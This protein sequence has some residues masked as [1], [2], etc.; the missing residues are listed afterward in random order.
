[1]SEPTSLPTSQRSPSARRPRVSTMSRS[2]RPSAPPSSCRSDGLMYS[3][4]TDRAYRSAVLRSAPGCAPPDPSGRRIRSKQ[5]IRDIRTR[6]TVSFMP[7]YDPTLRGAPTPPSGETSAPARPKVA[8]RY[9]DC[10]SALLLDSTQL[11]R[12]SSNRDRNLCGNA[13][14]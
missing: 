1:M 13:N 11:D 4:A 2:Y 14:N 6:S 8:K 12:I 3:V 10:R 7:H 9:C 5:P